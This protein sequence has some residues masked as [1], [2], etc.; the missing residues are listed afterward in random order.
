MEKTNNAS[1]AT[2]LPILKECGDTT[3][4]EIKERKPA[5]AWKIFSFYSTRRK[6]KEGESREI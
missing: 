1:Q 4:P 5:R 2:K 6:E 3:V